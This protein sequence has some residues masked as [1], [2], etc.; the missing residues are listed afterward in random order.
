MKLYRNAI[1][2]VV[3]LAILA[4]AY[5]FAK[6]VKKDGEDDASDSEIL[7]IFD[8]E[9]DKIVEITLEN[10]D[11]KSVFVKETVKEKDEEGNEAEKKVWKASSPADLKIDSSSINSIAINFSSLRADKVIEENATD[12]SQYGLDDPVRISVKMDDGTVKTL[13]V[14]NKTPTESGYY[15]KEKDSS[16]VYLIGTYEGGKF[17]ISKNDF[18][19]K[20]LFTFEAADVKTLTLER[21]GSIVFT[22]NKVDNYEWQI[23]EPI[24]ADA[25]VSSISPMIEAISATK[26]KEFI[27]ENPADLSKYG[28]TNP[29]YSFE[30]ETSSGKNK[31]I[32]G[33]EKT[34]DTDIYAKLDSNDEVF[35]I[36]LTDYTFLDK[37]FKEIVDAFAYI[38]SIWDVSEIEVKIDGQT[39]NCTVDSTEGGDSENDKFTVNGKDATMEDEDGN[40]PFRKFYQALIGITLADVELDAQPQGEAEVIFT[41]KLKKAP[42]TMKV[43]FIPKDNLYCYVVKNGVYSGITVEKS[44]FDEVRTTYKTMMEVIEKAGQ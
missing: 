6:N 16:N 31:L 19:D 23:V 44:K 42:Y 43:E 26:I 21:Q 38:V 10:K 24:Q 9:T 34:K 17:T 33:N 36:S 18:R 15:A 8:L 37:P 13:E 5:A 27:E 28:L 32:L 1:I 30:F 25:N 20:T 35:T 29:R 14:G 2:L 41:Y 39:I 40:Q 11:G 7:R 12:L 22:A 4:G 3:V